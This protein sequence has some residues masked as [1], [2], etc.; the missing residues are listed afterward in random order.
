MHCATLCMRKERRKKMH[1]IILSAK[2]SIC[3]MDDLMRCNSLFTVGTLKGNIES[4][5]IVDHLDIK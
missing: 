2:F 4:N 5:I 1:D 3:A